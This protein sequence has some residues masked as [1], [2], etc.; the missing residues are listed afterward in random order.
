MQRAGFKEET[1]KRALTQGGTVVAWGKN[2]T[3][4]VFVAVTVPA[5][6]SGVVAMAAGEV[7]TVALRLD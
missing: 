3:N 1:V 2:V 6:L 7:H 4:E 5:G